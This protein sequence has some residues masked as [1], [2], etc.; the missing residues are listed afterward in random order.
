MENDQEVADTDA[1]HA[2][3]IEDILR[4]IKITDKAKINMGVRLCKFL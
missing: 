4:I 3:Y 1:Q 2:T